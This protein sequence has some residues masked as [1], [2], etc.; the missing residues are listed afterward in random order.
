MAVIRYIFSASPDGI[1]SKLQGLFVSIRL[2][3]N[4]AAAGRLV[5][6]LGKSSLTVPFPDPFMLLC[7]VAVNRNVLAFNGTIPARG[8]MFSDIAGPTTNGSSTSPNPVT[9]LLD[10]TTLANPNRHV[11]VLK[12]GPSLQRIWRQRPV[13]IAHVGNVVVGLLDVG[14]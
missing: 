7:T 14:P 8:E 12:L 13:Q 9:R 11:L 5:Q 3:A 4:S 6:P 1:T 10:C 2:V